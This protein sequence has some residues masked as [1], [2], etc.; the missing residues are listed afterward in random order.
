M[1]CFTSHIIKYKLNINQTFWA[2]NHTQKKKKYDKMELVY[3]V[4]RKREA[5]DLQIAGCIPRFFRWKKNTGEGTLHIKVVAQSYTT[6]SQTLVAT[7]TEDM[8]NHMRGKHGG[9]YTEGF[10]P[11]HIAGH[12]GPGGVG[13]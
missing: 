12:M 8:Q 10:Y 3:T 7:N 13:G 4:G 9:N 2:K 6:F 5:V 1:L 11:L